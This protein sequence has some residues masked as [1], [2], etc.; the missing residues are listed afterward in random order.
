RT[1]TL[2]RLGL[3]DAEGLDAERLAAAILV[4]DSRW[5][6]APAEIAANRRGQSGLWGFGISGDLPI[7]LVRMGLSD[8]PDLLL[9]MARAH[10]FWRAFGVATEMA[11]VSAA[12]PPAAERQ[13]QW[14]DALSASPAAELLDKPGGVFLRTDRALDDGDRLLLASSARL[15]VDAT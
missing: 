15:V 2:R 14:L 6:G 5:R 4:V 9:R 10:A 12:T 3:S 13:R 1:A 8:G 11:V 7:V